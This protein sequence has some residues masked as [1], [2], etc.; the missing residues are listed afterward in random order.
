[1][2]FFCGKNEFFDH[3][4]SEHYFFFLSFV[5]RGTPPTEQVHG[6]ELESQKRRQL[7]RKGTKVEGAG[8]RVRPFGQQE[9]AAGHRLEVGLQNCIFI[10]Y[11]ACI[12][13]IYFTFFILFVY[14]YYYCILFTYFIMNFTFFIFIFVFL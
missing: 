11:F 13:I 5:H 8:Q 10:M 9:W 4:F 7:R 3:F 6:A 12:F 2:S 1:V 14:Y